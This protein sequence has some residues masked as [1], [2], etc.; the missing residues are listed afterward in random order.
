MQKTE[1]GIELDKQIVNIFIIV[2]VCFLILV[3]I[4]AYVISKNQVLKAINE[5]HPRKPH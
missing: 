2:F 4:V 3:G 1:E 5:T